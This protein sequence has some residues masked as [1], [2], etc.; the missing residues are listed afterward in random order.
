MTIF[1]HSLTNRIEWTTMESLSVSLISHPV[2]PDV[3]KVKVRGVLHPGSIT[4]LEKELQ[5]LYSGRTSPKVIFDLSETLF[6]S[7]GGW[8][9]FLDCRKQLRESGGELLLAGMRTDVLETFE[10]L[11]FDKTFR[12]FPTADQAIT[13]GLGKQPIP[14]FSWDAG[15]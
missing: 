8:S 13:Q 7:S 14:S 3:I 9:V 2:H 11:G 10:L 6:V 4:L 15:P 12:F 1:R 5:V